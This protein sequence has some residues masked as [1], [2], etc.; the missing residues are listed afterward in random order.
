MNGSLMTAQ[1]MNGYCF[2]DEKIYEWGVFSFPY[3][4]HC[5]Q[6][7]LKW[8]HPHKLDLFDNLDTTYRIACI[9]YNIVGEKYNLP[10]A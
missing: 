9:V 2:H 5:T 4:H 3:L 7:Y 6:F 1:Y 10:F 8:P